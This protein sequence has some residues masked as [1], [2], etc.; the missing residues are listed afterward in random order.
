MTNYQFYLQADLQQYAG[1]WVAIADEKIVA[2]GKSSKQVAQ[3]AQAGYPGKPLLLSFVPGN[4]AM[5]F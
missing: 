3:A 1:E 4:E 2:H 5:I